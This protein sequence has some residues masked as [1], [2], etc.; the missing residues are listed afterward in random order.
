MPIEINANFLN[1]VN[2]CFIP[3][4]SLYGYTLRITSGFRSVEEQNQIYEQ[5]RTIDGHIITEAPGGRSI[6]NF[7]FAVDVVD[8]WKEYDIDFD[9]LGKIA[10]YCG[11]EHDDD[12]DLSHFE[13][14]DGL[15][16]DQFLEGSRPSI[17]V[18]PFLPCAIIDEQAKVS[19]LLTLK[20][21]QNC[22]VP[23]F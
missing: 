10:E 12:G 23:K 17:M 3:I 19:Q 13:H 9:R 2:K 7:G 14:R 18:L 6:H 4:A 11:L 8:R 16:T 15:T 1:Q 21:L 20:D 22:G 5:G